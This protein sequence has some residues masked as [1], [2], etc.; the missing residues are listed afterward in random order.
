LVY[1]LHSVP[2]WASFSVHAALAEMGVAF[3]RRVLDPDAGDLASPQHRAR[4]PLGLIPALDTPDGTLFE[5]GAILLWL[6]ERHGLAPAPGS[7]G[8]AAF[9]SW[10][11][12][13]N[14]GIHPAVMDLLYPD[15]RAG[16]ACMAAVAGVAHATLVERLALI[17]AM[18]MRDRPSWLSPDAPSVLSIYL[19]HL[20]R[21]IAAFPH[22][23]EQRI[24]AEGYPALQAILQALETRPAIL[25]AAAAEGLVGRHFFSKPES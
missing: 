13:V 5:T 17:E 24:T 20:M 19:S 11:V 18:V 12:F 2:D 21:W 3:E 6:S 15:R 8:R 1:V 16:E 9:L 10:F 25:R 22:F 23:P 7:P 4:H 14:N